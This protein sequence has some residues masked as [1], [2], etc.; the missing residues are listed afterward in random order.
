V[1]EVIRQ[2]QSSGIPIRL[3]GRT[4]FDEPI[5]DGVISRDDKGAPIRDGS[6]DELLASAEVFANGTRL[7]GPAAQTVI[8]VE[9]PAFAGSRFDL[10]VAAHGA[11]VRHVAKLW[12]LNSDVLEES[13][14]DPDHGARH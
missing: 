5:V 2:L 4:R 13:V 9:T 10:R 3:S 14:P 8:V 1:A 6:I 12:R 7:A 11:V